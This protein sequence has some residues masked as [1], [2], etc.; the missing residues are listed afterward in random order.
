MTHHTVVKNVAESL[1]LFDHLQ[2]T[3]GS[4]VN[5]A[6]EKYS[7]ISLSISKAESLPVQSS[8]LSETTKKSKPQVYGLDGSNKDSNE[9]KGDNS[10]LDG[11]LYGSDGDFDATDFEIVLG[12]R[13]NFQDSPPAKGEKQSNHKNKIGKSEKK[14]DLARVKRGLAGINTDDKLTLTSTALPLSTT[15]QPFSKDTTD[16][17]TAAEVEHS[18]HDDL[19]AIESSGD[20]EILD[21]TTQ[22]LSHSNSSVRLTETPYT[23]YSRADAGNSTDITQDDEP[24]DAVTCNT[25]EDGQTCWEP[26][27]DEFGGKDGT[28]QEEGNDGGE[29][30]VLAETNMTRDGKAEDNSGKIQPTDSNND[31]ST[32]TIFPLRT[33]STA[34]PSLEP[35]DIV[36]SDEV[37]QDSEI[38]ENLPTTATNW[39]EE[40]SVL[41]TSEIRSTTPSNENGEIN[42]SQI[43]AKIQITIPSKEEENRTTSSIIEDQVPTASSSAPTNEDKRD[44][45]G[46][47]SV[48][49]TQFIMSI[50]TTEAT[51]SLD[52]TA[53]FEGMKTDLL[54]S[55]T[56]KPFQA[57]TPISVTTAE[58]VNTTFKN[59]KDATKTVALTLEITESSTAQETTPQSANTTTKTTEPPNTIPIPTT[60]AKTTVIPETTSQTTIETKSTTP[61][62]I[63]GGPCSSSDQQGDESPQQQ[64]CGNLVGVDCVN[65][66]CQCNTEWYQLGD[67]CKEREF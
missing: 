44:A 7:K 63:L 52:T 24:L 38:L 14:F 23:N 60:T 18:S 8:S 57:T 26:S 21:G 2:V 1:N 61:S 46:T 41:S 56:T 17:T 12:E 66:V 25:G 50:L 47:T 9:E 65:G 11:E 32:K 19:K 33:E 36:K 54:S 31:G 27:V 42:T 45:I 20:G 30:V 35:P 48:A 15:N 39:N 28:N 43:T 16:N 55:D 22:E 51:T 3:H 4:E 5:S 6:T 59:T 62:P 13:I 64:L 49:T 10:F 37:T 40:E 29:E 34:V 67:T 58:E 53:D